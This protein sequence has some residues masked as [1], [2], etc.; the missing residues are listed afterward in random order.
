MEGVS[1]DPGFNPKYSARF[2]K[3]KN[4]RDSTASWEEGFAKILARDAEFQGKKVVFRREM[5][6]FGMPD[7]REKVAG[8]RIQDP[9]STICYLPLH[10]Q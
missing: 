8:M 10:L 2:G 1:P 6:H 9:S 3:R 7:F 4:L 5:T